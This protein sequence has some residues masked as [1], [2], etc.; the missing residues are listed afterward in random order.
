MQQADLLARL[1]SAK[2]RF[3]ELERQKLQITEEQHALR[4]EYR[5]LEELIKHSQVTEGTPADERKSGRP[6]KSVG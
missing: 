3:E 6:K 4:G 2:S 5:L 1:E